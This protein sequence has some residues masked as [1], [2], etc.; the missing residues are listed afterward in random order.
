MEA[1][2]GRGRAL[3]GVRPFEAHEDDVIGLQQ[4]VVH[5][6]RGDQETVPG[7][8]FSRS[9]GARAEITGS[10]PVQSRGGHAAAIS[11]WRRSG[12]PGPRIKSAQTLA[13]RRARAEF[14][15]DRRYESCRRQIEGR[16]AYRLIVR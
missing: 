4:F 16:V 3:A 15:D 10:A 12:M 7:A 9:L 14:G 2:F 8:G 13:R 11:F 6:A 5:A 1:P